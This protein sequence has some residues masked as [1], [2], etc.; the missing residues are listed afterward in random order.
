MAILF[1][2]VRP[3]NSFFKPPRYLPTKKLK[4]DQ[5]TT[6]ACVAVIELTTEG[7]SRRSIQ[8][9]LGISKSAVQR[10]TQEWKSSTV[11]LDGRD[12]SHRYVKEID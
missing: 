10:V 5:S 3:Q 2:V 8:Q 7:C 1:S 9:K 6:I 11:M 4:N 12:I